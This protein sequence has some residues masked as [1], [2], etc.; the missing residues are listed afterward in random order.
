MEEE[1]LDKE[2]VG[3]DA[4]SGGAGI[5]DAISTSCMEAN[6]PLSKRT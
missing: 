3:L 5:K 1:L 2:S 4:G 6:V